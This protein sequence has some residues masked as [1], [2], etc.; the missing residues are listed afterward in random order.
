MGGANPNGASFSVTNQT[1]MIS[2]TLNQSAA[3]GQN[4]TTQKVALE[5]NLYGKV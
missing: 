5:R 1:G 3:L 4:S 2:S